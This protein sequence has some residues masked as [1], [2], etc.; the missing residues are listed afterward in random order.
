MR[1]KARRASPRPAPP[2]LRLA[3]PAC[4]RLPSGDLGGQPRRLCDVT[5]ARVLGA[6]ARSYKGRRRAASQC[7]PCSPLFCVSFCRRSPALISFWPAISLNPNTVSSRRRSW[8]GRWRRVLRAGGRTA[9]ALALLEAGGTWA[10]PSLRLF[11]TRCRPCSPTPPLD[12]A[13]PPLASR[14]HGAPWVP[15]RAG[16]RAGEGASRT[17][18]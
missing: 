3:R 4:L 12:S 14:L 1:I 2:R 9:G 13:R 11:G 7:W 8:E 10:W 15:G 18:D 5:G 16:G 6:C 17:R